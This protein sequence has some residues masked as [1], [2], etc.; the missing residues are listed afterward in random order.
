LVA[1]YLVKT[2][3]GEGLGAA[4]LGASILGVILHISLVFILHRKE[5]RLLHK[6]HK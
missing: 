5:S 6:R 1:Y 4:Y 3:G 2:F